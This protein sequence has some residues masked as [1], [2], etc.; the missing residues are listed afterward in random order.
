MKKVILIVI[1]L[2][3]S[4]GRKNNKELKESSNKYDTVEKS[5]SVDS[6][7]L[8]HK[9]VKEFKF[10]QLYNDSEFSLGSIYVN[11]D[12]GKYKFEKEYP[13]FLIDSTVTEDEKYQILL[14]LENEN[15]SAKDKN[16][17]SVRNFRV[18]HIN[19]RGNLLTILF[20]KEKGEKWK[21]IDII[22]IGKAIDMKEYQYEMEGNQYLSFS[23]YN[24]KQNQYFGLVINKINKS[25]KYE[26]VLRAFKF[27]LEKEKI[28]EINLK[29]EKIECFPEIGDE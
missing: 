29:R 27:D 3:L 9:I 7:Q 18:S 13:D 21:V 10:G 5:Y 8:K 23:C 25:G 2:L 6:L 20:K 26:K 19:N 28:V 14:Q 12:S 22:K 1:V 17:I 24:N 4:C 11:Y 16:I 15:L